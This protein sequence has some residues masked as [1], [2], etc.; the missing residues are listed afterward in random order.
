M[1]FFQWR[2]V[3]VT[4]NQGEFGQEHR[5]IGWISFKEAFAVHEISRSNIILKNSLKWSHQEPR[6]FCSQNTQI[7][8]WTMYIIPGREGCWVIVQRTTGHLMGYLSVQQSIW[9]KQS[10]LMGATAECMTSQGSQLWWWAE[11]WTHNSSF[12]MR[13]EAPWMHVS[14]LKAWHKDVCEQSL[15]LLLLHQTE[16]LPLNESKLHQQRFLDF[17]QKR[18]FHISLS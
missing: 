11:L 14:I 9:K 7:F 17:K 5:C 10:G 15:L 12:S 16:W 13:V 18:L 8:Q 2:K 4:C 6:L 3:Y 1:H